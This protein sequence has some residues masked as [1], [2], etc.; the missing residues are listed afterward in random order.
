[1][2]AG[3]PLLAFLVVVALPFLKTGPF[4]A[5]VAAWAIDG[6]QLYGLA[7]TTAGPVV[8]LPARTS[9]DS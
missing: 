5:E 3:R 8:G 2:G 6:V 9:L 7:V 4:D 1:M